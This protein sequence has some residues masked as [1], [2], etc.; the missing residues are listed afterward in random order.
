MD[1]A[2]ITELFDGLYDSAHFALAPLLAIAIGILLL[3]VSEIAGA[4]NSLRTSILVGFLGLSA[5]CQIKILGLEAQQNLYVLD[6]T[7][8]A[9]RATALWGLIFVTGTLLS[10]IYSNGFYGGSEKRFK[11]EHDVLV[12]CAPLGMMIMAGAQNLVVFFIGLELLSIPLYILCAYERSRRTSVEAGL[13]YFLLGSFGS[14]LF[15]YGSALL[16][17]GTGTLSLLEL[18]QAGEALSSPLCAAGIG[19]MVASLFFKLSVFPFHLWV[20]DVYQGSPTP[21]TALMAVGTKA[22]AFAFLIANTALLPSS[23]AA[24]IAVIALITMAAGNLGALAQTDLKRL[25]AYSGVAHAGT[26]LLVIAGNLGGGSGAETSALFYM[27]AY[28]FTVTGA[29]GL[30]TSFEAE[31]QST[32]L[33]SLRGLSRRAPKRAA[34]LALFMLSL[35]GIPATGG[36]LGKWFVFSV[37]VQADMLAVAVIGALLSLVALGYYL[38]VIALIYM[39]P[40]TESAAAGATQSLIPRPAAGIATIICSAGVIAMGLQPNWFLG[41]FG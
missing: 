2:Q 29:F 25:L 13:K 35:G 21:V 34:A 3:L 41:L 5:Y 31:G 24:L 8:V 36:F 1:T 4:A 32:S 22:A 26:V 39:Q 12:L 19:L 14:A 30:L 7:F 9:N 40:E 11:D 16:F 18:R 20:P 6:G 28:L 27:G 15:V 23:S 17:C 33:E 37:L 10:W 38:R